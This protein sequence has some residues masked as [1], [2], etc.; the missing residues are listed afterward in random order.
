MLP[1]LLVRCYELVTA[2]ITTRPVIDVIL[3]GRI[4][5]TSKLET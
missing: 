4:E 2:L 1:H 5:N 3:T